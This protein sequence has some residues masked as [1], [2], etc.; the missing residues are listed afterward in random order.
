MTP[1]GTTVTTMRSTPVSTPRLTDHD[2]R[3]RARAREVGN[4]PEDRNCEYA[5]DK[6]PARAA[7]YVLGRAKHLLR[8]QDEIITRQAAIIAELD[9]VIAR[10][11]GKDG[12]GA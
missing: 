10:L 2:D 3:T 9:A 1:P 6:N 8:E 11:S 12:G 7:G 4:L 5:G